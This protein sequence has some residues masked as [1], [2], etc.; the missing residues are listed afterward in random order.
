MS[1]ALISAH[2]SIV[3]GF[4]LVVLFQFVVFGFGHYVNEALPAVTRS[5]YGDSQIVARTYPIMYYGLGVYMHAYIYSN[6]WA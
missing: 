6:A 1:S 3:R 5:L 4:V 2:L